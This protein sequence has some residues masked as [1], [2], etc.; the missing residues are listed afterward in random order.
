MNEEILHAIINRF[1][2]L[3]VLADISISFLNFK[4][5]FRF[6]KQL[7]VD[8]KVLLNCFSSYYI[9]YVAFEGNF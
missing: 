1:I 9:D 4:L 6:F 2:F 7:F 5:R 8:C 3:E